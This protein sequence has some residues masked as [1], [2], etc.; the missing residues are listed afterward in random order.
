MQVQRSS[1]V[2]VVFASGRMDY[3]L[4]IGVKIGRIELCILQN[5]ASTCMIKEPVKLW[6]NVKKSIIESCADVVAG[7]ERD[8]VDRH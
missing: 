5:L 4:G 2:C 8:P 1:E 6:R 7:A 3:Q